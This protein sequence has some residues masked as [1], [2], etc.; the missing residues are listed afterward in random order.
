[1]K[2]SF[3]LCAFC[4]F[5][6]LSSFLPRGYLQIT[7][8]IFEIKE[9]MRGGRNALALHELALR[10]LKSNVILALSIGRPPRQAGAFVIW[11]LGVDRCPTR[12]RLL[13]NAVRNPV[14]LTFDTVV[15]NHQ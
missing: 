14:L 10:H 2:G 7:V 5:L 9:I 11:I 8:A 1:M 12:C 3:S 15:F 6:W 13:I 4:A